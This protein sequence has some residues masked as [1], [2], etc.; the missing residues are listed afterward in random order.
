MKPF[1]T[2]STS[3]SLNV[4]LY[5]DKFMDITERIVELEG[6]NSSVPMVPESELEAVREEVRLLKEEN[7]ILKI[8]VT[9]NRRLGE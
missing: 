1:G 3:V 6:E 9:E 5:G 8:N 4:K 7:V 2:L